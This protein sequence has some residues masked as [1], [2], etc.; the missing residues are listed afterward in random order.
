MQYLGEQSDDDGHPRR[1][2]H[3]PNISLTP[4]LV[5]TLVCIQ[6]V[7]SLGAS[8]E[9]ISIKIEQAYLVDRQIQYRERCGMY[10]SIP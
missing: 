2:S 9:D 7:S 5:M 10:P 1:V 3:P 8:Q 4:L 6:E